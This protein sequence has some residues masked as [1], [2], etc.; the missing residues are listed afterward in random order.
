M[1]PRLTAIYN[2]IS[3]MDQLGYNKSRLASGKGDALLLNLIQVHHLVIKDASLIGRPFQHEQVLLHP[4]GMQMPAVFRYTLE[5]H[6]ADLLLRSISLSWKGFTREFEIGYEIPP[7]P[8]L[9]EKLREMV[10]A[11]PAAEET[12]IIKITL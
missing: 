8:E 7:A 6:P 9:M 1:H 5:P 11:L 2:H 12:G 3:V 10:M 4:E